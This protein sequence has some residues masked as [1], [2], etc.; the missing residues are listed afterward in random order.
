MSIDNILK[1]LNYEL[2]EAKLHILVILELRSNVEEYLTFDFFLRCRLLL[3]VG[4]HQDYLQLVVHSSEELRT[5][6]KLALPDLTF[7]LNLLS[8][9]E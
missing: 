9:V 5:Y 7:M 6:L 1:I 4:N 8:L 2:D 3:M